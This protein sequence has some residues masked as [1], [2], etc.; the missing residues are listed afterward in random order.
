MDGKTG[1]HKSKR[2]EAKT[3][4]SGVSEG[5]GRRLGVGEGSAGSSWAVQPERGGEG[6]AF[7]G[8]GRASAW[9]LSDV[10]AVRPGGGPE[11]KGLQSWPRALRYPAGHTALLGLTF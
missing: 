3:R 2:S 8:E 10:S 1:N 4:A 7:K 5:L 9:H 11:V 6:G